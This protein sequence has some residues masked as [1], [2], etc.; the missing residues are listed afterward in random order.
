[1]NNLSDT[2]RDLHADD[3]CVT[4]HVLDLE[5]GL[6]SAGMGVSIS[7]LSPGGEALLTRAVT[8]DQGRLE[9]PLLTT[10]ATQAG[11]H[12]IAFDTANGFFGRIRIEFD[13]ADPARHYHVPLIL[14]PFGFS[15]YRGAPP[16]RSPAPAPRA[17]ASAASAATLASGAPPGSLGPGLTVH[18]IDM[19]QGIGAGGMALEVSRPSAAA[20]TGFV[21]N[22]EGRTADWLVGPGCLEAGQYEIRFD[23]ARYFEAT[24]TKSF[25]TRALIGFRV[26]DA[27]LHH[28]IPLLVAPAGYSCYRGS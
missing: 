9:A 2:P 1:M 17:A 19:A 27:E 12:V 8:N 6:P 16:H 21:T 26:T 22:A 18:V 13:L 28:H 11:T 23:L 20:S 10:A 5:K 4:T 3:A 24:G 14:S 7:R 25:F 15:T